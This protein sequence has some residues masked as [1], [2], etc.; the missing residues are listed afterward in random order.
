MTDS[1]NEQHPGPDRH[2]LRTAL[3][4]IA[5]ILAAGAV[6][7][8]TVVIDGSQIGVLIPIFVAVAIALRSAN[9]G[10]ACGRRHAK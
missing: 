9:R 6:V 1:Q 4:T 7:I 2:R 8:N 10:I 5:L 3:W